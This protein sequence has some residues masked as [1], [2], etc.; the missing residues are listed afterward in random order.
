MNQDNWHFRSERS[1]YGNIVFR[2]N[3]L[4]QATDDKFSMH[5]E[6]K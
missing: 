4:E 5:E 1:L 2:E 3:S 6:N